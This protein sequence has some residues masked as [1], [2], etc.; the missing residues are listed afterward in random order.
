[1]RKSATPNGAKIAQSL[2]AFRDE[3]DAA[4]DSR[5]MRVQYGGRILEDEEALEYRA[6]ADLAPDEK[7]MMERIYAQMRAHDDLAANQHDDDDPDPTNPEPNP[8][9]PS[10]YRG[11]GGGGGGAPMAVER[12]DAAPAGVLAAASAPAVAAGAVGASVA[13][14]P[15]STASRIAAD[16]AAGGSGGAG[17]TA[18][19]GG[20]VGV[21]GTAGLSDEEGLAELAFEQRVSRMPAALQR[22]MRQCNDAMRSLEET[23]SRYPDAPLRSLL[24]EMES[25][26]ERGAGGLP[27]DSEV[28]R[29]VEQMR[30]LSLEPGGRARGWKEELRRLQAAYKKQ[31]KRPMPVSVEQQAY[32][33]WEFARKRAAADLPDD[34]RHTNM[35]ARATI[36][37]T[38]ARQLPPPQILSYVFNRKSNPIADAAPLPSHANPRIPVNSD[39]ASAPSPAAA[40]STGLTTGLAAGDVRGMPPPPPRS[41]SRRSAR[42]QPSSGSLAK[43]AKRE[44]VAPL[45]AS[46]PA[47]NPS[48]SPSPMSL[49][50][51]AKASPSAY[52]SA[53]A[54]SADAAGSAL[55]RASGPISDAGAAAASAGPICSAGP[56]AAVSAGPIDSAGAAAAV[57][58]GPI[59]SA[60]SAVAFVAGS[61]SGGC[62]GAAIKPDARPISLPRLRFSVAGV[63]AASVAAVPGPA[64]AGTPRLK[65]NAAVWVTEQEDGR[66]NPQPATRTPPSSYATAGTRPRAP[67]APPAPVELP[68]PP[69]A[70]PRREHQAFF[71][72]PAEP[73]AA[74]TAHLTA[75]VPPATTPMPPLPPL[76]DPLPPPNTSASLLPTSLGLSVRVS[77]PERMATQT[78]SAAPTSSVRA[79][80]ST[81]RMESETRISGAGCGSAVAPENAALAQSAA[82]GAAHTTPIRR[83]SATRPTDQRNRQFN[84][85]HAPKHKAREEGQAKA[86]LVHHVSSQTAPRSQGNANAGAA[87]SVRRRVR[88]ADKELK[89]MEKLDHLTEIQLHAA[90]HAGQTHAASGL[91]LLEGDLLDG[92]NSDIVVTYLG[93]RPRALQKDDQQ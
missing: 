82:T 70:S 62:L 32:Y 34:L 77:G 7:D 5:M 28:D 80:R 17:P 14:T 27:A 85:P 8:Q 87:D 65:S 84:Q 11:G 69:P 67:P 19:A 66:E 43:T 31:H 4:N 72:V 50:F 3:T 57:A 10:I 81:T 37:Q 18:P 36:R 90:P 91:K 55:A 33:I 15:V 79:E 76:P 9:A 30:R 6:F 71:R 25:E 38:G 2:R 22:Y 42:L 49:F 92:S 35:V 56:A 45:S 53:S 86:P 44:H 20:V 52:A 75:T 41:A 54:S 74:T 1:M 58:A 47:P 16:V 51:L 64:P 26:R 12:P 46:L 21:R 13:A 23:T 60:G 61:A 63:A 29:A 78:P 73:E 59:C 39:P 24:K 93:M 89:R 40:S 83:L 68:L 88:F 48:Q